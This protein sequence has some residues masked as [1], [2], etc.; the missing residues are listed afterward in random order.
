MY[1]GITTITI[2]NTVQSWFEAVI[3]NTLHHSKTLLH[4]P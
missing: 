1:V 2:Y 4:A 3:N